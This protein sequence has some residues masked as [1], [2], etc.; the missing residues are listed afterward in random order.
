MN[1]P[2]L[3]AMAVL[4]ALSASVGYATRKSYKYP[5]G[6]AIPREEYEVKTGY[7]FWNDEGEELF[8]EA[9]RADLIVMATFTG[10]REDVFYG[11]KNIV[12]VEKVYRGDV[13]FKGEL[14]AVYT[15][16]HF[17]DYVKQYVES[18]HFLQMREGERYY[19]FLRRK[20]YFKDYQDSLPYYEFKV[21][22]FW[23]FGV[24]AEKDVKRP[25]VGKDKPVIYKDVAEYEFIF[26]S[27]EEYEHAMSIKH[28]MIDMYCAEEITG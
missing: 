19:L 2:L 8:E 28:R 16:D 1:K 15:I 23:G 18:G 3:I 7:V 12:K 27:D 26:F 11:V 24:L 9:D 10:E 20:E 14:I 13:G 17:D 4:V 5:D 21:Y 25:P 22:P 6:D